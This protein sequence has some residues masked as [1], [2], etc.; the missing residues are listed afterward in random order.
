MA[1]LPKI[2]KGVKRKKKKKMGPGADDKFDDSFPGD[3]LSPV[4]EVPK[5]FELQFA[6]EP[7]P[8]MCVPDDS[9]R[10]SQTHE[11]DNSSC[12]LNGDGEKASDRDPNKPHETD[13][14]YGPAQLWYDM[15]DVSLAGTNFDYGFKVKGKD[16]T[17]EKSG[18]EDE[19]FQE[20]P[21][22]EDKVTPTGYE[23]DSEEDVPDDCFHMVTQYNWEEDIIWS[24][25]DMKHK[26]QCILMRVKEF[27]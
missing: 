6:H 11:L 15:L 26:V 24:G 20:A 3:D 21:L 2:W 14:R 12:C 9:V 8:Y 16:A 17:G 4:P 19:G 23:A 27:D 5:G 10:F 25:D 18:E 7:P 22:K 13:W 1:N